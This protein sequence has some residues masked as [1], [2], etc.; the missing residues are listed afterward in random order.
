MLGGGHCSRFCKT[1]ED[2]PSGISDRRRPSD[3]SQWLYPDTT[4]CDRFSCYIN[5]PARKKGCCCNE[6][7]SSVVFRGSVYVGLQTVARRAEPRALSYYLCFTCSCSTNTRVYFNSV[8][9][10]S[11]TCFGSL[12]L[13]T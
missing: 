1:K 11:S 5:R 9:I 6:A 4:I 8:I 13:Y 2:L 10:T 12:Y 7:F 3:Y